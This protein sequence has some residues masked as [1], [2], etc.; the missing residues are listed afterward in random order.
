MWPEVQ[1]EMPERSEEA[2]QGRHH[3]CGGGGCLQ[4]QPLPCD[5]GLVQQS[6]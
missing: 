1:I 2:L 6:I 4:K 3:N 5:D